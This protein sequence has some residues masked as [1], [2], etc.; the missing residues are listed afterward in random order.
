MT[1]CPCCLH[2]GDPGP[3]FERVLLDAING[4]NLFVLIC[5]KCGILFRNI[6]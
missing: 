2:K 4:S 6:K 3:D 5:R 1:E